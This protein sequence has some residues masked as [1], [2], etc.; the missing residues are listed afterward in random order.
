MDLHQGP[1]ILHTLDQVRFILKFGHE[2]P[3]I[4]RRFSLEGALLSFRFAGG[5]AIEAAA[6]LRIYRLTQLLNEQKHV[7]RLYL[8]RAFGF[9]IL[10]S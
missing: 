8:S 10:L 2:V 1:K 9:K 7:R 6:I 4:R 3:R 5:K